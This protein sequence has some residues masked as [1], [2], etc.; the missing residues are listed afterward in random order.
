MLT[1]ITALHQ[2]LYE[3]TLNVALSSK[4][5]WLDSFPHIHTGME[6]SSET[7]LVCSVGNTLGAGAICQCKGMTIS[8]HSPACKLRSAAAPC[9]VSANGCS[10]ELSRTQTGFF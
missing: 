4:G 6:R 7:T 2:M 3:K 10:A 5:G 8:H 9:G 1:L